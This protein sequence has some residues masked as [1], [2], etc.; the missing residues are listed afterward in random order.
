MIVYSNAMPCLSNQIIMVFAFTS[1]VHGCH[2]YK[3]I[4]KDEI[5]SEYFVLLNQIML[6]IIMLC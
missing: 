2:V 6:M 1:I 5:S 4:N 3:D